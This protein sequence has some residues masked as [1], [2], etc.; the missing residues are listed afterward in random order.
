[1]LGY[2]M[3]GSNDLERSKRFYEELFSAVGFARLVDLKAGGACWGPPGWGRGSSV[4]MFCVVS[5]IDGNPATFGNGTMIGFALSCPKDV[6]RIYEAA[7]RLGG[8][9]EGEPGLREINVPG[10]Y[11]AYFRDLD[12]NKLVA[13]F[14]VEP[15]SAE[16]GHLKKLY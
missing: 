1:V 6:D 3:V 8:V 2:A 9:D 13:Y 16:A 4:S 7:M 14:I 15:G 10:F 5:P 11:G 12:N